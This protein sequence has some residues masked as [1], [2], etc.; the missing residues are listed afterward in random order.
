MLPEKWGYLSLPPGH[1]AR[2]AMKFAPNTPT[3]SHKIFQILESKI[4]SAFPTLA[5]I[6]R[7]TYNP[8]NGN[9]LGHSRHV[10]RTPH[11]GRTRLPA[12]PLDAGS[13]TAHAGRSPS[14]AHRQT[15]LLRH[16]TY[17]NLFESSWSASW[18]VRHSPRSSPTTPVGSSWAGSCSGSIAMPT[19][20]TTVRGGLRDRR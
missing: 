3:Q 1:R 18:V 12:A 19:A 9:P 8:A 13:A 5:P 16:Q 6:K 17:A 14:H 2:G 7:L 4:L 20:Q 15:H 11:H 10:C